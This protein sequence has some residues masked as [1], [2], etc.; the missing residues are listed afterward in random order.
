MV[1]CERQQ[2]TLVPGHP[3]G[4]PF[5]AIGRAPLGS[6]YGRPFEAGTGHLSGV[7]RQLQLMGFDGD[8]VQVAARPSS[9]MSSEAPKRPHLAPPRGRGASRCRSRPG[10]VACLFVLP[11]RPPAARRHQ[12]LGSDLGRDPGAAAG[13]E[14]LRRDPGPAVAELAA[15]SAAR[16]AGDRAVHLDPAA[17]RARGSSPR[18]GPRRSPTSSRGEHRWTLYFL[19]SGA[20][21]WS[22]MVV[23]W[24]P[25]LIAAALPPRSPGCSRSSPRWAS[26]SG[27]AGPTGRR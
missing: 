10:L 19:I 17:A 11:V 22:W 25:L 9:D 21:L 6:R 7:G 8:P 23:Q 4:Q 27:R 12:R 16:P 24:A 13:R 20:M 15:V 3:A 26:R 5:Q 18:W 14:S 2:A 1:S